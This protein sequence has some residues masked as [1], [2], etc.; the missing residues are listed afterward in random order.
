MTPIIIAGVSLIARRW[1]NE[2]GGMLIGLPLTSGPVSMFFTLEQGRQFAS[3]AANTAMVGTIP[4]VTFYLAYMFAARV[5]KWY[6]AA[7]FSLTSYFLA[8]LFFSYVTPTPLITAFLIPLTLWAAY[9][10]LGST[11]NQV[12]AVPVP[13]WDIPMRVVTATG[14]VVIVT[15]TAS[16]MGSLWSGLLSAFPIFS[17]VMSTFSHSQGGT[18]ALKPYFKGAVLGLYSYYAFFI[19]VNVFITRA[20]SVLVYSSAT[21]LALLINLIF[22]R[23]R[24]INNRKEPAVEIDKVNQTSEV[25]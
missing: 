6:F 19:V 5:M 3:S 15:S 1:G 8:L 9:Q 12:K 17:V 10:I 21:A 13:W 7:I 16:H 25:V 4:V 23:V 14:L 22:M 11:E 24:I 18:A 2:I 20:N